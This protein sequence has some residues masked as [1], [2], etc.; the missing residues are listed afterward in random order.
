MQKKLQIKHFNVQILER[1][2]FDH[3]PLFK[4]SIKNLP[5]TTNVKYESDENEQIIIETENKNFT[6][7]RSN[8]NPY[9]YI[10]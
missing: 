6:F 2:S 5:E 4:V 10:D 1:F 7:L 8:F 3:G 9:S